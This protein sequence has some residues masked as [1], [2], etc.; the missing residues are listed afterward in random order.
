MFHVFEQVVALFDADVLVHTTGNR[1][2]SVNAFS[3]SDADDFLPELAQQHALFG[4]FRIRGSNAD[5][6][7]L[8]DI[9]IETEQQVG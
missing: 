2:G 5:D 9:G 1:A 3:R 6:I 4:D 8:G 7:A